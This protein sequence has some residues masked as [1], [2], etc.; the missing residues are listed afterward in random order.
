MISLK[1]PKVKRGLNFFFFFVE[2]PY[3]YTLMAV[4]YGSELLV[5]RLCGTLLCMKNCSPALP[6]RKANPTN[7]DLGRHENINH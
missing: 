1:V 3:I 7:T 4:N 5:P 2:I 6:S